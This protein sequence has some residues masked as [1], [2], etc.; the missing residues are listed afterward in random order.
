METIHTRVDHNLLDVELL[1]YV[2]LLNM[3]VVNI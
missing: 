3:R 2:E 1:I